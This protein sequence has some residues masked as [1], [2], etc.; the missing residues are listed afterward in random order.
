M[1]EALRG[2][3]E[4]ISAACGQQPADVTVVFYAGQTARTTSRSWLHGLHY[5]G[6][7]RACAART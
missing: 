1:I 2:Q 5:I 3:Y 4:A 6:S 7:V